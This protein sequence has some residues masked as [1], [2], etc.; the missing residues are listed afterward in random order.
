MPNANLTSFLQLHL[1]VF[2]WGFTGV[3]GDIIQLEPGRL[4]W[5][6]LLLAS[7]F[8]LIY[9]LWKKM[10]LRISP[11]ELLKLT[12]VGIL[13]GI[14][15][16]L[17]FQ[18]IDVSNVSVTL[19]LFSTGAFLAALLEPLFYKRKM[20]WYELVLGLVIIAALYLI[21]QAEFH[22]LYGMVLAF[23]SVLFGVLFTLCN[24]KLTQRHDS[25]LITLYEFFAA[26]L[27]V[28]VYLFFTDGY[29]SDF[30]QISTQDWWLLLLLASVCT[31]YAFTA[32]VKVMRKLSP[33]TVMLT[34]NLE[35][36]YGI[37]MAYFIIGGKEKMSLPF[38]LGAVVIVLVVILNGIIKQRTTEAA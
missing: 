10:D 2:I 11:K 23:V 4:T 33:Y 28:C 6:R 5:F 8:M 21:V 25:S 3:L 20:L 38:Y 1:I 32:S 35:P 34:T 31:A 18:A 29:H 9:L 22:Y 27:F 24:G 17:F 16:I 37:L 12:G 14:H 30:F 15:W 7:G 26:F 13:I 19:A 36:V